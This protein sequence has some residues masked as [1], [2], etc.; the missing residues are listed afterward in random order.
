[1][2]RLPKAMRPAAVCGTC[3][4]YRQHFVMSIHQR[5]TPV[6]YGHCN[7]P[8]NRHTAPDETCT[9]WD[10]SPSVSHSNFTKDILLPPA[11]KPPM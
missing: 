7:L 1:M 6:W 10:E 8:S 2:E 3:V 11:G 5:L 4:H 9:H